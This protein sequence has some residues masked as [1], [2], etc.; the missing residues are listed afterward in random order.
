MGE[1]PG[2]RL[3]H[4]SE[5]DT[6]DGTLRER[7]SSCGTGKTLIRTSCHKLTPMCALGLDKPKPYFQDVT[8]R[9]RYPSPFHRSGGPTESGHRTH[10]KAANRRRD[11]Q[12][13]PFTD[14]YTID[15]L[16]HQQRQRAGSPKPDARTRRQRSSKTT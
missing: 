2:K 4:T 1:G 6:R 13:Q 10:S 16:L 15:K 12:Q 8:K 11:E 3:A 14:A 5:K 9:A 7:A